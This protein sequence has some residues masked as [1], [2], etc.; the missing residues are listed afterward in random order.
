MLTKAV[1]TR[2][3]KRQLNL[4][5]ARHK[6]STCPA[7]I[8][9]IT[10][11]GTL[12]RVSRPF[13]VRPYMYKISLIGALGIFV[14]EEQNIHCLVSSSS[15]WQKDPKVCVLSYCLW[16]GE[17][18]DFIS[19]FRVARGPLYKALPVIMEKLGAED[20]GPVNTLKRF[21]EL[22]NE[23]KW[24]FDIYW[25]SENDVAFSL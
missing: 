10:F 6:I 5:G 16:S 24:P 3:P 1:L 7:N 18:S 9:K 8:A 23:I 12:W 19:E 20:K 4:I 25:Q 2:Y 11:I 22:L 14:K 15:H 21:Y 17:F 13:V